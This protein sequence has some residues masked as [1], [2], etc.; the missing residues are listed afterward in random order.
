MRLGD[1]DALKEAFADMREGY[2]IFSD[3]E[4]VSTKDIA[5]I[6]DNA[7]TAFDCRSCKNNGN[8]R[9]CVNCHDYSNYVHYDKRPQGEWIVQSHSMIMNCS[10]CGHEENAKDVG[11]IDTDKHF[12]SFCGAKMKGGAE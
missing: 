2:P 11:T 5:S 4:M 12:C 10:L 7:S 1:L 9:E 6:I 8:E 3:T